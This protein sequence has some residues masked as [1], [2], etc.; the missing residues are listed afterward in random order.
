MKK[1]TLALV[2]IMALGQWGCGSAFWEDLA[3]GQPDQRDLVAEVERVDTSPRE[4]H[5]RENNG[6]TS[7]VGYDA[8]TRVIYRGREYSVNQLEAGDIVAVELKGGLLGKSYANLIRVQESVRDRGGITTRPGTGIQTVDGTV[9]RVDT[10][11]WEIR[12]R[13]S[14]GRTRV[15]TY[16]SDTRVL[17]RGREYPVTQLEAGDIVTVELKEDSR[18]NSYTNLIRVQESVRDRGGITTRPGTGLLT[19]D[20]RVEQ[21]DFQRSSFEIRG[22]SGERIFVSLPYNARRSD[23]DRF[24]ALQAGDYVRVE[25]RFL[26]RE[27]FELETF[28][29]DDR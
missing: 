2:M 11:P 18:G 25:G 17:Y 29:R 13:E 7:V 4:I 28:L 9:E 10:S 27:R 8:S 24:R 23:V 12:I 16:Y 1:L 5:L 14:S 21:V 19:V 15:V 20:G 3:T 6:R 22:Q 26:D